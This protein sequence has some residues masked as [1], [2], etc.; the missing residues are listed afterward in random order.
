MIPKQ[1]LRAL[2]E[3]VPKL[4]PVLA[5]G[6]ARTHMRDSENYL[7]AVFRSVASGFPPGLTY[8]GCRRC[9]PQE[10]FAE[11]TKPKNNRRIYDT[12]RSDVYMMRYEFRY[13]NEEPIKKF[14]YLPF[15]GQAGTIF[16]SGS[17]FMISP[18][19]ADRVISVGT[20]TIFIRLLKAKLTF[21]RLNHPYVAAGHVENIPVPWSD[22]Y[23]KKTKFSRP[24]VKAEST[25]VHYLLSKYGFSGM[26]E[27][28]LG[29]QPIVGTD[30]ITPENYPPKDWVICHTAGIKPKGVKIAFPS[31]Y[32]Q[33]KSPI[34]VA[35]R[36]TEYT[37]EARSLIA[38]FFYVVDHFPQ[39]IAPEYVDDTRLW[40]VLLGHVLW[41]ANFSEGKLYGDVRDHFLS[42]DEYVD[43][44]SR[45]KLRQIGYPCSD[46]YE[47]LFLIIR[48]FNDW[49]ADADDRVSTMYD[50][51][52]A[53]L[54]FVFYGIIKQINQ[55]SFNLASVR[56]KET[57]IAKVNDLLNRWLR[58]GLIYSL[59]KDSGVCTTAATSGDNMAL[60]IT[61]NL[62]PQ[63][64]SNRQTSSKAR[65]VI[66]D[67]T[68]RLHS[69]IAEVGNYIALPKSSP[70]G[71][72]RLNLCV[73]VDPTGL[74]VR[75]E[76]FRKRIDH[77]QEM[78]RNSR[79]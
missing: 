20:A 28:F 41:P 58:P 59:T 52:L 18:I 60:K 51:E 38:G 37:S 29:I 69:S 79:N 14:L 11:A 57:T 10:E 66:S 53:I 9:T 30:N 74:I 27:R 24:T 7:D 8:V 31:T 16:L 23:I 6:L 67:P 56:K 40:L 5:E 36:K 17:R 45:D 78:I 42:L 50:K 12:A 1:A 70:D 49:R 3:E 43:A 62:V 61:N 4:N 2:D 46:I 33:I 39:R 26:F 64:S 73:N 35:I 75:N 48:N 65:T 55:L 21:N 47:L 13:N 54:Q 44:I 72:A 32:E 68:K 63:S 34:K 15:V 77:V 22:I 76:K 71:R 25:L 19:L